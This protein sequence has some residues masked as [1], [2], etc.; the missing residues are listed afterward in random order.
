MYLGKKW[1]PKRERANGLVYRAVKSGKL[2]KPTHCE[3]CGEAKRLVGHHD[4]YDKPLD[5]RWLC[6]SCHRRFHSGTI[7]RL[8][9]KS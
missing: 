4:D 6:L 3:N 1:D 9:P 2:K 8:P 5:V 7:L